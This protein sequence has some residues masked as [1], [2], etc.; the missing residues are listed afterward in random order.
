MFFEKVAAGAR[1]GCWKSGVV[2]YPFGMVAQS[3][4]RENSTPNQYLYN[5]KELQ[6][7]LDL[8]WL[9]YGAR[10][11]MPEIG[12][13]STIDPKAIEYY[14][15]SPYNYTGGNPVK[16]V[17]I[18]GEN[19][20]DVVA[21]ASSFVASKVRSVAL[22]IGVGLVKSIKSLIN[23]TEVALYGE[24]NA[25][26]SIGGQ[27]AAKVSGVGLDVNGSDVQLLGGKLEASSNKGISTEGNYLLKDGEKKTS[28]GV[29]VGAGAEGGYNLERVI[30]SKTNDVLQKTT[31]TTGG[32]GEGGVGMVTKTEVNENAVSGQTT[33]TVKDAVGGGVALGVGI[34]V[35]A[36]VEIGVKV[37]TKKDNENK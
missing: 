31:T 5:G 4:S 29:S 2:Y 10:M 23:K 18:N 24:V 1:E 19:W 12:K 32:F 14:S 6:D 37:S 30:D 13:F 35:R 26:V 7:E 33:T 27:G 20:R 11:Y 9:D 36:N 3:Y 34:V 16:R 8:G 28:A 22:G 15:W 21:K 17:D 25:S